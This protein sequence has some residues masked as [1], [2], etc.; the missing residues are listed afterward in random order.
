MNLLKRILH[1]IFHL[2]FPHICIGCGSDLVGRK[3]FLCI[4]CLNDLPETNFHPHED[5][6][7][8]KIFWGRLPLTNATS[9]FYFSKGGVMQR[10]MHQL[11]YKGNQELGLQLG[12]IMGAGLKNVQRFSDT[13]VL[14]PIPLFHAKERRR[15]YNQ[16]VLICNGLAEILNIPVLEG[17][18]VRIQDTETQTK[19]SRTERWKN[20]EGMFRLENA[21]AI[22][23][24]HV[25]LVDD[26][27]TT[28]AT[29]EACSSE[30]MK[31]GCSSV[32]IAT[33][34]YAAHR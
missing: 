9:H 25:L 23:G 10:L 16:S 27:I 13:E 17:I 18:V 32:S 24:K 19:K 33:L 12:K 22:A 21:A 7:V 34:C 15:G 31:A 29:L 26:V 3:N 11:K 20:M 8:E 6:P 2:F 1:S 28:G 4:Q 30:L 5:N 14:I